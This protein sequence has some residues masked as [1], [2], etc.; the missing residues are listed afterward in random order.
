MSWTREGVGVA[1]LVGERR[2]VRH[3]P[4]ALGQRHD[5]E[6]AA[7]VMALVAGHQVGEQ[8]ELLRLKRELQV[9][10]RLLGRA[11]AGQGKAF[12][13]PVAL[14]RRAVGQPAGI[15]V[16]AGEGGRRLLRRK[17]QAAQPHLLDEH[18]DRRT[19]LVKARRRA[20]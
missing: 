3:V 1:H 14:G 20:G 8:R 11:A 4:F 19:D 2:G 17:R 7:E 12:D 13:L 5:N 18:G 15:L 9:L 16:Q 10:H 6:V